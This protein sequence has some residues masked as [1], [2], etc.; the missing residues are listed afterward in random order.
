LV[1]CKADLRY[2]GERYA[3]RNKSVIAPEQVSSRPIGHH[4]R[5]KHLI[6]GPWQGEAVRQRIGALKYVE[7][8]AKYNHGVGRVFEVAARAALLGD[9]RR[10][11]SFCKFL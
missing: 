2:T 6:S 7:C 3:S 11:G 1:G 5:N 10:H 4:Y 8:S 9:K